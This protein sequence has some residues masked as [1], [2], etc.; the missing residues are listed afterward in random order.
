M[1]Y[2]RRQNLQ[3]WVF[4]FNFIKSVPYYL[5]LT[6]LCFYISVNMHVCELHVC[7]CFILPPPY[8]LQTSSAWRLRT[9]GRK[10]APHTMKSNKGAGEGVRWSKGGQR[11]TWRVH[12]DTHGERSSWRGLRLEDK[13]SYLQPGAP[14]THCCC[15]CCIHTHSRQGG[16]WCV[17][18][19]VCVTMREYPNYSELSWAWL[20][21]GVRCAFLL[22]CRTTLETLKQGLMLLE[23]DS[24]TDRERAAPTQR[25]K[26][27]Q[28]QRDKDVRR[29]VLTDR[30]P[31]WIGRRH[32]LRRG[33]KVHR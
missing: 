19:C 33:E 11:A 28:Q 1:F 27:P 25:V 9:R 22:L 30:F 18:V 32:E 24:G 3:R 31:L 4:S 5:L 2:R 15:C 14:A 6:W 16:C 20:D 8:L 23:A 12:T 29:H 10:R 7:V 26:A 17:R 13:R 21:G